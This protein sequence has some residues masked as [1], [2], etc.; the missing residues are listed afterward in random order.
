LSNSDTTYLKDNLN[1]FETKIIECKRSINSKDP[2]VKTY[3]VLIYNKLKER[4][5][6]S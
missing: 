2:S 3:E 6:K 1:E 5:E 4:L